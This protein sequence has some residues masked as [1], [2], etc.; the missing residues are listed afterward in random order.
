MHPRLQQFLR[1]EAWFLAVFIILFFYYDFH[2]VISEKP[3]GPH[4]WRQSD[5]ASMA[6]NYYKNTANLFEPQIH[7]QIFGNGKTAGEFPIVYWLVGMLYRIFGPH[8][9]IFRIVNL[10]FLWVGLIF[11]GKTIRLITDDKFWSWAI[12]ILIFASPV[13]VF[14]TF[15]FLPEPPSMGLSMI[16]WYYFF[17]F[18]EKTENRHL[19]WSLA[20]F[21]LA[22]LIKI[23]SAISLI[24]IGGIFF[25]EWNKWGKFGD[26]QIFSGKKRIYLASFIV[27]LV[28]ILSWYGYA[29]W[30]NGHNEVHY[31]RMAPLPIIN[32]KQGDFYFIIHRLFTAM[33]EWAYYPFTHLVILFLTAMI[34]SSKG[35]KYPLLFGISLLTFFGVLMYFFFFF[36]LFT[37]HDYFMMMMLLFPMWVFIHAAFII[38]ND[39][40]TL[41]NSWVF[42][43]VVLAFVVLNVYHTRWQTR[44]TAPEFKEHPTFYD[45]GF[46]PWLSKIGVSPDKKVISLPDKS[47]NNTLYLMGRKGWS[48]YTVSLIPYHI[49][50]F[51]RE[52]AEYL[53]LSDTTLFSQDGFPPLLTQAVGDYK[54]IYVFKLSPISQE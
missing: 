49:H 7:N 39:F 13:L 15:G 30:Y 48:T 32:V 27:S 20:F 5:C 31:F 21:T 41:N 10:L 17:L 19:I 12:P 9:G 50:Q 25:I 24:A 52:G 29:S 11:L 53:I 51:Q 18:R 46:E 54:G 4:I 14:Y 37:V 44:K 36:Q 26:K 2:L 23:S 35:R 22:G 40:P 43:L 8:E 3:N 42:R 38:K 6:W 1:F 16:G 33:G 47:P 45:P 28:I 34:F